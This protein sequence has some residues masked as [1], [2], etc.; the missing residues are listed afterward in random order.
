MNKL[1]ELS[2][3]AQDSIPPYLTTEILRLC[4]KV[5]LDEKT[6]TVVLFSNS[7]E[8]ILKG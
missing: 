2:K 5:G 7:L 1:F 4:R 8:L 3:D 6:N